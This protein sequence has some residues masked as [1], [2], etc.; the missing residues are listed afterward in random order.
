MTGDSY[1]GDTGADSSGIGDLFS[2]FNLNSAI[3]S[4]VQAFGIYEGAQTAKTAANK[5]SSSSLM[6]VI[7]G[8]GAL[9]VLALL[10]IKH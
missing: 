5:L 10:V 4:G 2:G 8:V 1:G 9:G 3:T 6:Y 7:L